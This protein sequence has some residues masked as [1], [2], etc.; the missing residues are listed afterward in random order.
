MTVGLGYFN[1]G[2]PVLKFGTIGADV[3]KTTKEHS[4]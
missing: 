4:R 1:L 3:M 2:L